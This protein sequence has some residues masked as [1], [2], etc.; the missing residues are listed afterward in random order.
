MPNIYCGNNSLDGSLV[1]GNKTLGTRY[2][3]LQ[4][5]IGVGLNQPYDPSYNNYEPID[6]RKIYCG[7]QRNLPNGY[8]I[9]GN[10]HQCLTK[11]IGVGKKIKAERYFLN[12]QEEYEG[13]VFYDADMSPKITMNNNIYNKII[14]FFVL[15][16]I[17][18]ATMY[19]TKPM[20]I[21][22]QKDDKTQEIDFKKFCLYYIPIISIVLLILCFV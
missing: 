19:I 22:K 5:G 1:N 7:N 10:L 12:N 9:M 18:F 21:L 20:F 4:K 6:R 2:S 15:S 14:I 11:G 13:D 8:D 3:C 17:I 16:V